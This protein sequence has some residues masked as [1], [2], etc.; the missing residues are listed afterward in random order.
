MKCRR[1]ARALRTWKSA[2]CEPPGRLVQG[3]DGL[4]APADPEAPAVWMLDALAGAA[5]AAGSQARR[6]QVRQILLAEGM[7][8]RR[9]RSRIRST[10]PDFVPKPAAVL[11][12]DT[13]PPP[14]TT[15]VYADELGPVIPRSFPPAPGW[16]VDGHWVKAELAYGRGP[17]KTWCSVPCTL[18][19][20]MRSL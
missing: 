7:R 10:D 13:D 20:A 8:W 18:V 15:V 11:A 1:I 6:S 14:E 5:W 3:D 19:M 2:Q 9:T 4:L 17:E 12:C 16:T